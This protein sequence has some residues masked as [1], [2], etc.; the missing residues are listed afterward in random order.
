MHIHGQFITF[1]TNYPFLFLFNF[2]FKVK[3][4]IYYVYYLIFSRV[5]NEPNQLDNSSKL[6]LI[7]NS[8][9]LVHEPNNMNLS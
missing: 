8:L 3:N 5:D 9:N 6:D 4:C 2:C 1:H 7:I